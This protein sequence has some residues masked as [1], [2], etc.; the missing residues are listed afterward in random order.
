MF[1]F[2]ILSSYTC[3]KA[4]SINLWILILVDV[5]N[6]SMFFSLPIAIKNSPRNRE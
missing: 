6:D 4:V 5:L 3:F 1:G 2:H